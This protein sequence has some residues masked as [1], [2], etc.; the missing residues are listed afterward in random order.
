M[1]ADGEK[2]HYTAVKRCLVY[3]TE[4]SEIIMVITH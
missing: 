4:L 1:I 2:W 3:Y